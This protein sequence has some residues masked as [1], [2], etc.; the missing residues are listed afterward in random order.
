MKNVFRPSKTLGEE[1]DFVR[2]YLEIES[3]RSDLNPRE[4]GTLVTIEIR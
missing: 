1:I 2:R 4:T 3:S